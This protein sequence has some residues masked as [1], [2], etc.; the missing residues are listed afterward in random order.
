MGSE[1]CGFAW[2]VGDAA[3]YRSDIGRMVLLLLW[4]AMGGRVRRYIRSLRG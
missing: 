2:V 3:G 4:Q 1:V